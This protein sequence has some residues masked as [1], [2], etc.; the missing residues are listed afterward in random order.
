MTDDFDISRF[1]SYQEDNRREIKK[2]RDGLPMSLWETYSAFANCY[3]G[4]II[5]GIKENIDG[6]WY[7]TGLQNASRLLKEFW[8]TINNPR[9][10]SLNILREDDVQIF[11]YKENVIM[12]IHVP[13]ARR[14]QKP[15]YINN[16]IWS[17]TFRRNWE[18]DYHCTRT[19]VRAMLRDEPEA[20]MDMTILEEFTIDDLNAGSID[21]YRN[22]HSSIHP[23][24]VWSEL[25][26]E[27]YLEM[28]GAVGRINGSSEL[29]PT[30]AGLLM[31]GDEY[32]IVRYFPD[33]FLDY[34]ENMSP[35]IRWTDRLH[36]S[37]GDWSGNLFDFFFKV[38]NR[39]SVDIP[40]PFVL[41][42]VFRVDDTPVH[43]AVR[44]ALVNCLV[45]ADFYIPRGLV[46]LREPGKIE[47]QNPGNIRTGK[48]QMLRGGISDPRN[49]AIM[50]MFHLISIG[51]R[52]GSGVPGIFYVWKEKGWEEPSVEEQFG[53]DR[54]ILTL[55]FKARASEGNQE[56]YNIPTDANC[57]L[58]EAN[59]IEF[60]ANPWD[61]DIDFDA[62]NRNVDANH[63]DF[64]ASQS[65]INVKYEANANIP[66]ANHD[67]KYK[68]LYKDIMDNLRLNPKMTQTSLADATGVSRATIQRAMKT[69]IEKGLITREGSTRG[70]WK[71]LV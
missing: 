64:E 46:I 29:H 41:D 54:T 61:M 25:P 28:I 8:D 51:E 42:G 35:S 18:G 68:K 71:V 39:I 31:F 48:E 30:A 2:A 58:C 32:Q 45:N 52:A 5:L 7:P 23:T 12:V 49:K 9:K 20:T 53:P 62:N 44:E 19:E 36:S 60:N 34:R 65:S 15:V 11:N 37:S 55:S 24:H 3:G 70:F 63:G 13:P 17:G 43:K 27:K 67:I 66:D 50:K 10:I 4:V 16:D 33:Y 14:E 21:R 1:D 38:Y 40:K 22:Y 59:T 26:K 56:T 47:L 57:N 6:S 69:M